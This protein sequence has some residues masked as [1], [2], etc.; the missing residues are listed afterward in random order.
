M[1]PGFV[2]ITPVEG[3]VVFCAN[4]VC[5]GWLL[6]NENAG[7]VVPKVLVAG[8]FPKKFGLGWFRLENIATKKII[9]K[10]SMCDELLP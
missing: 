1:N 9:K 7:A 4:K 6:G 3:V 2:P 8:L 10:T 5:C